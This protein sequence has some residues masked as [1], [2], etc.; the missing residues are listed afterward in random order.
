MKLL[1]EGPQAHGSEG[2][3]EANE[4]MMTCEKTFTCLQKVG[5]HLTGIDFFF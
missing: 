4:T 2:T 1:L 3:N 5:I